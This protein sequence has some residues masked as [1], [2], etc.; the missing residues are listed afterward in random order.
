M[1]TL[2]QQGILLIGTLIGAIT[3]TKTGYIY[4]WITYPMIIIGLIL[5]ITQGQLT[6]IIIAGTL[7]IILLIG[8]KLG[9]SGRDKLFT[10]ISLLNPYNNPE[11][12]ITTI[13]TASILSMT[14]YSTYYIIKYLKKGKIKKEKNEI[15]KAIIYSTIIIGYFAI[16]LNLK[17]IKI[18]TTIILGIPITLGIIFI[19]FQNG[20]KENFFEKKIKL[21]NA[22]EDE[23]LSKNNPQKILNLVNGKE[24]VEEK[25]LTILKKHKIKEIIVLRNLPKFGPFIFLGTIIALTHPTLITTLLI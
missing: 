16:L 1:I 10:A 13:F 8:Y 5:S 12:I 17:M 9:K 20:I 22:E 25:E 3:D 18:E 6:N 24:L 7:F 21:K 4:D 23:I 11:F 14:F 2:I 15:K 19:A